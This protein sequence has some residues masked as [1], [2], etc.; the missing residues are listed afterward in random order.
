M[1]VFAL[2]VYLLLQIAFIPLAVI[3]IALTGYKQI[4]VSKRLGVSQTAIEIVNGRWTMHI[5]GI[6]H[7]PATAALISV[8]PNTSVIGLWLALF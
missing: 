1:K 8:L 2:I 4:A 7:D 3:G 5:F 6:R